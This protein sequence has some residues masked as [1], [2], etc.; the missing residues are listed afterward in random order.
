MTANNLLVELIDNSVNSDGDELS[1]GGI[2]LPGSW[3]QYRVEEKVLH[4]YVLAVGPGKQNEKG[5]T[6]P[7]EISVGDRVAVDRSSGD[8]VEVDGKT[9]KIYN[10][11]DI[12]C[13]IDEVPNES[14]TNYPIKSD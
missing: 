9:L 4:G 7:M 2:L 14:N 13:L 3:K 8:S 10:E 5:V 6:I 1:A 11:K 12:I